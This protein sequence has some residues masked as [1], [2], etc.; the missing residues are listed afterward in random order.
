MDLFD[1]KVNNANWNLE[2]KS[3]ILFDSASISFDSLSFM[4]KE[5]QLM[6]NGALAKA[7]TRMFNASFKNFDIAAFNILLKSAGLKLAGKL[8]GSFRIN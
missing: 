7:E 2:R 1:V 5:Q 8:T 3:K 6:L 4:S